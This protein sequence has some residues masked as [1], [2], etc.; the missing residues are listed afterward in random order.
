MGPQRK[1]CIAVVG[2]T[3]KMGG[4]FEGGFQTVWMPVED[5]PPEG[6]VPLCRTYEISINGEVQMKGLCEYCSK[7]ETCP[8]RKK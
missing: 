5:A 8:Y 1:I 3:L 6:F 4:R 7:E 2:G